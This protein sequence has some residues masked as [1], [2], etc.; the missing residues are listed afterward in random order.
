[1]DE[2]LQEL[3]DDAKVTYGLDTYYLKDHHIFERKNNHFTFS[4]EWLPDHT[5]PTADGNNPDGTAIIDIDIATKA[6]KSII[7][8]N[9][10]TFAKDGVL[11]T[12]DKDNLLD[13]VEQ[14]TGLIYDKQFEITEDQADFVHFQ[15]RIDHIEV[16]PTG[17]I[18]VSFNV[19][20]AITSFLIDG[21]FPDESAIDSEPFGLI[22]E[23]TLE[24]AKLNCKLID[25]PI[26]STDAWIPFY[27]I[28]D[29]YV[30]N[31]CI[32]TIS[33][34]TINENKTFM[35]MNEVL[36]WETPL[37]R[38][39]MPSNLNKSTEVTLEH[40]LQPIEALTEIEV[41][42]CVEETCFIIQHQFPNDS[43]KWIL[44]NLQRRH[45]YII[46]E[47]KEV[48]APH[49]ALERKI[50]VILDAK[51]YTVVNMMD[52][53]VLLQMLEHFKAPETGKITIDTAFE[54]L[55]EHIKIDPIYVYKK[56]TKTY[57]IHGKLTCDYAVN[58]I[59]GKLVTTKSILN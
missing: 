35:T 20:G 50:N 30:T 31:D 58:A 54:Q 13:W 17:N 38:R 46:A 23:N 55:I 44:R 19:D 51:T 25:I 12:K 40:A 53:G 28:E 7:F 39:F 15:A 8:I 10:K 5:E 45:K 18:K 24:I 57:K 9:E 11:P 47:V 16:A 21:F 36:K 41:E 27:F 52:N 59:T 4:M 33:P 32:D 26:E 56:E 42:K 22:K 3:I 1:M 43:G 2:R 14:T 48:D 6:L 49:R 29:M 37:K 34:T